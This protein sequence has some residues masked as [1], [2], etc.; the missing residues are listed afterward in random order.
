MDSAGSWRSFCTRAPYIH[1]G[2]TQASY[3]VVDTSLGYGGKVIEVN[4]FQVR[5]GVQE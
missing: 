5:F 4:I 1:K 3:S 2:A